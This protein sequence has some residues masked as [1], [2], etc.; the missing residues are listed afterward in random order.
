MFRLDL[1]FL[2]DFLLPIGFLA[3]AVCFLTLLFS[4]LGFLLGNHHLLKTFH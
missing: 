3:L 2:S 4:H 1:F